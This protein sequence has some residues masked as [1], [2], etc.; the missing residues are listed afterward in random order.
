MKES[1][2]HLDTYFLWKDALLERN[3]FFKRV[4]FDLQTA[5]A[6][7]AFNFQYEFP[8]TFAVTDTVR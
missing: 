5:Y 3:L 6:E 4:F 7:R 1:S 2:Y 8:M